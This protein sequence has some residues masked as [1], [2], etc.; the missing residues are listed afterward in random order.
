MFVGFFFFVLGWVL[1][2]VLRRNGVLGGGFVGS[3]WV[4]CWGGGVVLGWGVLWGVIVCLFLKPGFKRWV[5]KIGPLLVLLGGGRNFM[6]FFWYGG[7]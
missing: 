3:L 1:F 4:V 2:G 7:L 6:F 5:L